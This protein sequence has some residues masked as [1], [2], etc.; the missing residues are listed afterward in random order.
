M[1]F[2]RLHKPLHWLAQCVTIELQHIP[3]LEGGGAANAAPE[4]GEQRT[5]NRERPCGATDEA[6]E[7]CERF[8]LR[9]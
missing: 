7:E 8:A 9:G 4:N 6:V 1:S 3:P 5:E 2:V